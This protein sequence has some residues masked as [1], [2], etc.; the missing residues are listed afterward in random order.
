M[1]LGLCLSSGIG[2]AIEVMAHSWEPAALMGT[3]VI[4]ELTAIASRAA[5]A[6]LAIDQS[7]VE[8]RAKADL[9][10]VTAADEAANAVIVPA[11]S[12]L[13][14]GVPVVSEESIR[15]SALGPCFALVDPL[16]GTREF[17]AGRNE[18]T[19]NIALVLDGRPVV[20]IIAAPALGLIWRGVAARGAER[21]RL[22]A[23]AE[24]RQASETL[25]MRTR[26]RPGSGLIATASRSHF[27]AASDAFLERLP[28]ATRLFCGSSLKFC[29]IAEGAADVYARLARTC[30]WDV[31]AG[32]AIVAA[33]G[34]MVTKPDGTELLYGRAAEGFHIPGFIAWGDP[35][36]AQELLKKDT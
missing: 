14:R 13:L 36:A 11:L 3:A 22:A 12:Q 16:D 29:R 34:G 35:K 24:P 20:G 7:K 31:A 27:D 23:G 1:R 4:D 18:F 15:P 32:H 8:W 5:A 17:L 21:L 6:V 2:Q 28:V 33:A 19:V 26:P 9:S 30:E 25:A 10:P